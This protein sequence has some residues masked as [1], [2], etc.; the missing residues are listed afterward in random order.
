MRKQRERLEYVLKNNNTVAGN[1]G[2]GIV[3]EE[4]KKLNFN[5][6]NTE[7]GVPDSTSEKKPKKGFDFSSPE[8]DNAVQSKSEWAG[9]SGKTKD[10]LTESIK[11]TKYGISKL[12]EENFNLDENDPKDKALQDQLEKLAE[13]YYKEE[14]KN[15]KGAKARRA[16]NPKDEKYYNLAVEELKQNSETKLEIL[17]QRWVK[18]ESLSSVKTNKENN[19][20]LEKKYYELYHSKQEKNKAGFVE[21]HQ[22][23]AEARIALIEELGNKIE[24]DELK[25]YIQQKEEKAKQEQEAGKA[26]ADTQPPQ[27]KPV[28]TENDEAEKKETEKLMEHLATAY[29]PV[30]NRESV[31]RKLQEEQAQQDKNW[32]TMAEGYAPQEDRG[33]HGESKEQAKEQEI[34]T[35]K[36]KNLLETVKSLEKNPNE[37]KDLKKTMEGRRVYGSVMLKK[38]DGSFKKE[39]RYLT[40]ENIEQ[41]DDG[42]WKC[43]VIVYHKDGTINQA[44]SDKRKNYDISKIKHRKWETIDINT[45]KVPENNDTYITKHGKPIKLKVEKTEN[46]FI[47]KNANFDGEQE[48]FKRSLDQ[49][50]VCEGVYKDAIKPRPKTAQEKAK[51]QEKPASFLG[52]VQKSA[53][54]IGRGLKW[55]LW[56]WLPGG[57]KEV[58]K[59]KPKQGN[60]VKNGSRAQGGQVPLD[61]EAKVSEPGSVEKNAGKGEKVII[62]IGG[63]EIPFPKNTLSKLVGLGYAPGDSNMTDTTG[64]LQKNKIRM[65]HENNDPQYTIEVLIEDFN[66]E[67]PEVLR[68]EIRKEINRIQKNNRPTD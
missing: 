52:V 19:Q 33:R 50:R 53:K 34:K 2:G 4:D 39:G 56:D 13:N 25:N 8:L 40:L 12:G 3:K 22:N 26:A 66:N 24:E 55:L 58:E 14:S 59:E 23:E 64:F 63:Q 27:E 42:N 29:A 51:E 67:D 28:P 54:F 43:D 62:K 61:Q 38:P 1:V 44:E 20:E 49:L 37:L 35:P 17:H 7:Q 41:D 65:R 47:L 15:T 31:L 57:K 45:D 9:Q 36:K 16:L 5:N 11:A 46:G 30:G 21:P 68:E 48:G 10:S 60:K 18:L 32:R 6:M